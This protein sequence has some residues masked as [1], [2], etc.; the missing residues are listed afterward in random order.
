MTDLENTNTSDFKNQLLRSSRKRRIAAFIL[1]HVI[2]TF[3]IVS[4]IFLI[5]GPGYLDNTNSENTFLTILFG[6]IIGLGIYISKDCYKGISIGKW[7]LGIMVRDENNRN[8]VPTFGRLFLRN[9][10]IVVWPIEFIVLALSDDKKRIGDKV[11]KTIVLKNPNKPEKLPR[12][13]SLIG[14]GVMFFV[15]LMVFV[16]SALKSSEAYTLATKEIEKSTEIINE[17]GGIVG[18]GFMPTGNINVTGNEGQ[19]QLSITVKGKLKNVDVF[20]YLESKDGK[21]ELIE[22]IKK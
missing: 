1:D 22:L 4:I 18:Y 11:A 5:L 21:W 17:T 20:T 3:L 6:I 2:M 19:A 14:I 8:E 9:L 12:V 15:F 10:F 13:L 16:G 7:I